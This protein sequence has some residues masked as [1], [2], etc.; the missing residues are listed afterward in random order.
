[1]ITPKPSSK[2]EE[3]KSTY[4]LNGISNNNTKIINEVYERFLPSIQKLVIEHQ[5]NNF[6]ALDVFQDG[7]LILYKKTKISGFEV[8]SSFHTYFYAVCRFVW[9]NQLK[10]TKRIKYDDE[11]NGLFIAEIDIESEI[12]EIE[13][14]KLFDA[15]LKEL[16]IESQK[17]LQL[18]FNKVSIKEIA[19]IMGY[20]EAYAKRKNYKA[21]K[22]L[23]KLIRSDKQYPDLC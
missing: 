10:K 8:T 9:F 12:T 7:L 21:K 6:D 18:S 19:E 5:G 14:K 1:M 23:F 22:E 20:T 2:K 4:F 16:S 3:I 13:K 15:K 11:S 17:V